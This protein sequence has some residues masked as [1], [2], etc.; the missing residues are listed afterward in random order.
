MKGRN[1]K[2]GGE[3]EKRVIPGTGPTELQGQH[4]YST[5]QP[6]IPMALGLQTGRHG[7]ANRRV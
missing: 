5:L 6:A 1:K 4:F 3:R 7:R 2:R